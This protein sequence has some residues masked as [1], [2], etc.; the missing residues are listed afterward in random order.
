MVGTLLYRYAKEGGVMIGWC[1]FL[2]ELMM[3]ICTW[4]ICN[5]LSAIEKE[6]KKLN[7]KKVQDE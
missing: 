6:L 4:G 1:A 3:I 2:I 5:K 7:G